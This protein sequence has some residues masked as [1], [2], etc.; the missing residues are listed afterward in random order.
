M[1]MFA[2]YD[3]EV[4]EQVGESAFG[5]VLGPPV[6]GWRKPQLSKLCQKSHTASSSRV[7]HRKLILMTQL[8]SSF[9]KVQLFCGKEAH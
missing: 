2:R 6:I 4:E 8:W 7:I 1:I 9:V 3:C 5:R